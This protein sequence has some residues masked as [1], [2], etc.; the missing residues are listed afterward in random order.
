MAGRRKFRDMVPFWNE[1]RDDLEE[2]FYQAIHDYSIIVLDD[3]EQLF[4]ETI[5]AFYKDYD[6]GFGTRTYYIPRVTF[7]MMP[8]N[9]TIERKAFSDLRLGK[10]NSPSVRSRNAKRGYYIVHRSRTIN[11]GKRLRANRHSLKIYWR[12][13][14]ALYL[15]SERYGRKPEFDERAI[16][17]K[18]NNGMFSSMIT[19]N[20]DPKN[21]PQGV[22]RA[23]NEWIWEHA[24]NIGTHG[25]A[26]TGSKKHPGWLQMYNKPRGE[27]YNGQILSGRKAEQFL[28]N[29]KDFYVN[30]ENGQGHAKMNPT[31]QN[32]LQIKMKK[33]RQ[34]LRNGK[35]S[36]YVVEKYILPL[37][38]S[39]TYR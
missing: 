26:H 19:L 7:N 24:F 20:I 28:G 27:T 6:I 22:H 29:D 9:A 14:G 21:M 4:E 11:N 38:R 13:T 10:N 16:S 1:L 23:D 2:V 30:G 31:P 3:M 37:L 33:Y 15:A 5:D 12:R 34:D 18:N 17:I 32:L 8:W 36:N 25:Y 39:K 35:M